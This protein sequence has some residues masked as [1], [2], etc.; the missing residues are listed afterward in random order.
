MSRKVPLTLEQ[1]RRNGLLVARIRVA[2]S[3]I[4]VETSKAYPQKSVTDLSKALTL[5]DRWRSDLDDQ[6]HR[7][8]PELEHPAGAH[9]Y[10]PPEDADCPPLR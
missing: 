1:H 4:L 2:L 3:S 5:I 9:V 7:E 6:V 10:Y 8:H